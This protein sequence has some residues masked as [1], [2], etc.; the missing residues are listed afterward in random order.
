[1]AR[2]PLGGYGAVERVA[3]WD[4]ASS[5]EE[6]HCIKAMAS[7]EPSDHHQSVLVSFHHLVRV[8]LLQ[9]LLR[10]GASASSFWTLIGFD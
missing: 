4:S 5:V 6:S 1:M 3:R 7:F 8:G 2:A 9:L 10:S